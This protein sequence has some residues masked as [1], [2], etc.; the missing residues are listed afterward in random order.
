MKMKCPSG[1]EFEARQMCLDF[2]GQAARIVLPIIVK[3]HT[4][5]RAWEKPVRIVRAK[6][7]DMVLPLFQS[8]AEGLRA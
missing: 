7:A 3:L 6:L 1:E 4:N 5:L 8:P 2:F